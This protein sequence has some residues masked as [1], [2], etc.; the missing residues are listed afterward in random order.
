MARRKKRIDWARIR[1][2]TLTGWCKRHNDRIK[3]YTGKSCFTKGGELNDHTLRYLLNHPEIVKKIAKSH[4]K[5]ILR[6]I[7]F[8][9]YV[10]KG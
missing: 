2:G 1:W 5:R 4:Y 3:R 6:K 9:L 7:Q 10:L 8:K